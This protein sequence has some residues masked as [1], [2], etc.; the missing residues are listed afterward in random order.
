MAE[1]LNLDELERLAKVATEDFQARVQPWMMACFGAEISA[2][3][4]ERNHRFLEEALELVQACGATQSEAHQL[5]DYV[6][7][8]PVGEKVQEVGGVMVTLAALCLAQDLDM[9]A[10]G[11]TELAR[12]WTKVEQ[13]RAKQAAK[14]K[15]SPLPQHVSG[16]D[17]YKSGRYWLKKPI[18]EIE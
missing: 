17:I 1:Q 8:R 11:E 5:V 15:H 12:I 16:L 4:Q 9:H 10:A 3:A 2:D 18:Q 7:G 14:P 6:Y 13:I